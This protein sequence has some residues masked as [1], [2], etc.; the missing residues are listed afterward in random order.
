M[1]IDCNKFL[2]IVRQPPLEGQVRIATVARLIEKKGIEYGIQAIA[3]LQQQYP[4]LKYMIIGEGNFRDRLEHFITELGVENRVELL[5]WKSQNEVIEILNQSHLLLAPSVTGQKG[6]QEGIPVAIMEAMAMGLPII[7]TQYS[8]IPELV[9]DGVSGFLVP[10]RD[11]D[12][13]ARKLDSLMKNP[14]LCLSMGKAGRS[15]VENHYSIKQLI[16]Q[17][18]DIYHQS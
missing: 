16:Q 7:S 17:L 6:D 8:G 1:G 14:D 15:Y 4:N 2:F 10:E 11:A 12:A 18:I 5:G 9:E 3:K 13:I